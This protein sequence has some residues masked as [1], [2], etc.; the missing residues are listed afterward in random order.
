MSRAALATRLRTTPIRR[1]AL[2]PWLVLALLPWVASP[3]HL[4]LL[5][6]FMIFGIFAVSVDLLWGRT[7]LLSF[8]QAAFFGIGAYAYGILTT[9]ADFSGITYVG[10]LLA[11]VAP[12]LLALILGYFMFYG[13]IRDAYF[14]IVTIA[15]AVVLEQIAI[16]W[17][18]LTNGQNGIYGIKEFTISVPGLWEHAVVT[19]FGKAYV[20][21]VALVILYYLVQRIANSPFGQILLAIRDNERRTEF[22]GFNTAL[23]CVLVFVISAAIAGIAG[24]LYAS[25]ATFI[26]PSLLGLGF[27]TQVLIWVAVGGRATLFGAILGAFVV[28]ASQFYVSSW[29][30]ELWPVLI[31]L[32]FLVIVF[33]FPEGLVPYLQRGWLWVTGAPVRQR[34]T[35]RGGETEPGAGTGGGE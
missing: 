31:G 6:D 2:G 9:H 26:S 27:S 16:N 21:L 29:Q 5:R 32:L 24:A 3:L 8:G 35:H 34:A 23:Y 11:L 12:S 22:L 13:G 15:V 20:A 1:L 17:M 33:V 18:S 10:L 14:T 7:G 28:G 19:E 4:D 25:T 30:P